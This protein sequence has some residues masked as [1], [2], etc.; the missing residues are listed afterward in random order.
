MAIQD[1]NKGTDSICWKYDGKFVETR[2]DAIKDA[3]YY[4][5][6]NIVLVLSGASPSLRKLI[7]VH[8]NGE[9]LYILDPP[10]DYC[11]Y[12]LS[13]TNEEDEDEEEMAIACLDTANARGFEVFFKVES[14]THRLVRQ[15]RKI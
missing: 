5:N 12:Y 14:R 6:E 8:P 2:F 9:T 11:F 1:F 4:K 3:Q 15:S 7:G 13:S 10:D